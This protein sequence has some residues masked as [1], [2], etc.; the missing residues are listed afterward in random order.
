MQSVAVRK[1]GTYLE[2]YL[3]EHPDAVADLTQK[4]IESLSSIIPPTTPVPAHS[5]A[6]GAP[7]SGRV[8][9]AEHA[10]VSD[11]GDALEEEGGNDEDE[12]GAQ[13]PYILL[14]VS[15]LVAAVC[16]GV[17]FGALCH[18][19]LGG[20]RTREPLLSFQAMDAPREEEMAERG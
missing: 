2:E 8:G 20:L 17:A 12:V 14:A 5:T 13:N 1:A 15:L 9:N 10:L 3:D 19:R 11:D 16:T 6:T 4:A 18:A 7:E